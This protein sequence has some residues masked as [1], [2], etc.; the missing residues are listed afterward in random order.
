MDITKVYTTYQTNSQLPAV[1]VPMWPSKYLSM[2]E[3]GKIKTHR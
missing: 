3:T 1:L 2:K